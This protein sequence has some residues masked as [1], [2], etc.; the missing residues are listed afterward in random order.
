MENEDLYIGCTNNLKSRLLLHNSKKIKSTKNRAPFKL[1]YYEAFC[2]QKTR[3]SEKNFLKLDGVEI[4]SEK[5][6]N[7][8]SMIKKFER[9]NSSS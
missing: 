4:L 5:S 6:Y 9:I 8:I 1:V 3:T 7:T 2:T